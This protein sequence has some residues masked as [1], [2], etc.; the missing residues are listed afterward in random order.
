MR[1][2]EMERLWDEHTRGEFALRDVD[3]TMATMVPE[4]YV[5]HLPTLVGA[6]GQ[7]DV[8]RFYAEEFI[9]MEPPDL[10]L[11]LVSRTVGEERLVDE[12]I[13][14]MTH[15]REVPWILPGMAGTGK[16]IEVAVLAVVR[17]V[18]GLIAHEH[19]WWDQAS[20]LVQLDLLA[21]DGLPVHGTEIV[22]RLRALSG[23]LAPADVT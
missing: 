19:L 17:F 9:P 5:I 11:E 20:V 15:D 13:V 12:M 14:T 3:A 6:Q 1:A 7:H 2:D 22:D 21:A 23:S 18:D 16:R 8:R 4:P 10:A